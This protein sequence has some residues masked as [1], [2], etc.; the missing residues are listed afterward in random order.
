MLRPFALRRPA[1]LPELGALLGEHG[2]EA[3][4]YAGGTELLLLMKE[5]LIRPR[6]LL[7][8]KGV[9]GLGL[10]AATDDGVTIGA[11]ASHRTVERSAA[12]RAR[13]PLV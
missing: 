9:A 8:V 12:A 7:D 11:T 6:V 10:V 4:L 1:T 13:C 5:G 2:D 3:A